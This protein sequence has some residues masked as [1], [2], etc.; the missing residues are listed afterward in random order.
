MCWRI[1]LELIV[2]LVPGE[3]DAGN[4]ALD[5]AKGF[6]HIPPRFQGHAPAMDESTCY[7]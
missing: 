6:R 4:S 1:F 2:M 7:S 3:A 5:G